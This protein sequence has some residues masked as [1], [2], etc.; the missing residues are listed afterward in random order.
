MRGRRP[1]YAWG[2]ISVD[3]RIERLAKKILIREDGCHEWIGKRFKNAYGQI[4][5]ALEPKKTRYFLAHRVAWELAR[6]PIPDELMV[7]HRCDHPWCVNVE[8]LFLGT[9]QDNIDDMISKGRGNPLRGENAPR[10][11]LSTKQVS[12]IRER[13]ASGEI[14]QQALGAIYGVS[15]KQISV[16]CAGKQRLTG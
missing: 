4:G 14:T 13:Y 11:K 1:N 16:I 2:D 8:H 12:E 15:A 7:L 10:V 3:K 6:G 9:A 5:I